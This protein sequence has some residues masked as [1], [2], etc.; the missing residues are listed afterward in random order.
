[1]ALHNFIR[2]SH[3][4]DKEFDRCDNDESYQPLLDEGGGSVVTLGVK[5]WNQI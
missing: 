3:L 1:M 5:K 2:E 4:A